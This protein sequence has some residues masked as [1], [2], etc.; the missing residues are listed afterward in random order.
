MK[1]KI[2]ISESLIFEDYH[3]FNMSSLN[4]RK[5]SIS[6]IL[7]IIDQHHGERAKEEVYYPRNFRNNN[8]LRQPFLACS[9]AKNICDP[10]MGAFTIDR[11][12]YNA[13]QSLPRVEELP[14]ESKREKER[15]RKTEKER[16]SEGEGDREG[17]TKAT[18][19]GPTTISTGRGWFAWLMCAPWSHRR[20]IAFAEKLLELGRRSRF[21]L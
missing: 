17:A 9:P 15:E 10:S 6:Q 2:L 20:G 18:P 4:A 3:L 11:G 1:M 13:Y 19:F 21:D 12:G 14:Q 8:F 7:N 5:N 16:K